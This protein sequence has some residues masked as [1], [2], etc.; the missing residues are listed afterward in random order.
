MGQDSL[1]VMSYNLLNFPN[2]RDDCGSNLSVAARWDTLRKIVQY[3]KPDILMVCELQSEAGADNILNQALNVNNINYYSRA[4]FISNQ[5][6][7]GSSLNNMFFYNS[8]KVTLYNQSEVTTDLRDI[9]EYV[10]Y[11]N[12]PNLGFYNDTTFISFF[13][14]HL[15][16]GNWNAPVEENRRALECNSLRNYVNGLAQGS[17]IVFGG[18]FNFYTSNEAGYQILT[19]GGGNKLNDPINSPGNWNNNSAFANIHTQST[20]SSN[21]IECGAVGGMD[22]RFDI[23]LLS[24]SIIGGGNRVQYIN[25][26]YKAFG[27]DGNGFN[28]AINSPP[29]PSL[30]DSIIEALYYMSDHLPVVLNLSITYPNLLAST[31][32]FNNISCNGSCDGNATIAPIGGTLPHT[33]QWNDPALQTTSTATGLCSGTYMVTLTDNNGLSTV[34]TVS[35]SDPSILV[36]SFSNSIIVTCNGDSSGSASVLSSGGTTPYTYLWNDPSGQTNASAFGLSA[37]TYTVSVTDNNNCLDT[38]VVSI[39]ESSSSPMFA[40]ISTSTNILCS[41]YNTGLAIATTSGGSPPYTYQWNDPGNQTDSI[42]SGLIA[43]T[44]SVQVSDTSGCSILDTVNITE[45]PQLLLTVVDTG[46]ASC[47][48]ANST[49]NILVSGGNGPYTY[50][51]NDP[52]SQTTP[53]AT[54]LASGSYVII[55]TDANGC[56]DSSYATISDNQAPDVTITDSANVLCYGATNG[57]ATVT[58]IGGSAPYTYS[59]SPGISTDSTAQFLPA[60]TYFATVIDAAGCKTVKSVTITQPPQFITSIIDSSDVICSGDS[61]GTATVLALGGVSPYNYLWSNGDTNSIAQNLAPGIYTVLVSD[62]NGCIANDTLTPSSCFEI[63]SI[64]VDA[65]KQPGEPEGY[66]EMVRIHVGYNN[67]NT[68]D[69]FVNWPNNAWKG[70]CQNIITSNTVDSINSTING[71][72]QVVEPVG[73]V[74]P[75]GAQVMLITSIYF[76]WTSHNWSGLDYTLYLIFQCDS[77]KSG[78]FK[79]FC[80]SPCG[81]RTLEISFGLNCGDTVTYEPNLLLLSADGDGA[82]FDVAGNPTYNNSGC[83]PP[84]FTPDAPLSVTI[85]EPPLFTASIA[86]SSNLNCLDDSSG[87]ALVLASGGISP[88]TYLWNDASAQTDSIASGLIAGTYYALVWDNNG[89]KDSLTVTINNPPSPLNALMVDSSDI[90][91]NGSNTGFAEVLASGGTPPLSYLWNDPNTQTAAIANSLIAGNYLVQVTDANGCIDSALVLITEPPPITITL[92]SVTDANCG[93]FNGSAISIASGGVSPYTY[94][95]NDPMSQTDT[96]AN[97]LGPG[98]YTIMVTDSNNC[99][100]SVT[101]VINDLPGPGISIVGSSNLQCNG[102]S[103]GSASSLPGG[104]FPPYT[105][106]WNDPNAQTDSIATGLTAGT[107]TILVTDNYGC[108]ASDSIIITEPSAFSISISN[109]DAG[110]GLLNGT[111]NVNVSGGSPPYSYLWN[112]NPIQTSATATGLGTGSYIVVITDSNSCVD[113]LTSTISNLGGPTIMISDSTNILCNGNATGSATVSVTGGTS[114]FTYL[115]NDLNSQSNAIASGLLAGTYIVTVTDNGNCNS[116][117]SVTLIEPNALGILFSNNPV[118]CNGDSTGS[119]IVSVI[120]G[121][122]P[123]N[124]L[125]NDP[126]SQTDS[127][128]IGLSSGTYTVTI[129]DANNCTLIANDTIKEPNPLISIINTTPESCGNSDGTANITLSGGTPSYSYS[130]NTIPIQTNASATGLI[131]GNYIVVFNDLNGCVDSASASI[132]TISGPQISINNIVNISCNSG[133]DGAVDISISGGTAPYSYLWSNGA[134]TEDIQNLNAG[135]YTVVITDSSNCIDSATFVLSDPSAIVLSFSSTNESCGSNNGSI[136]ANIS[137]GIAPFTYQWD[138]PSA[139]TSSIATGLSA[140]NYSVSVTDSS[141]CFSSS[142]IAITNTEGPNIDTILVGNESCPEMLD[143]TLLAIISGGTL[144]YIYQWAGPVNSTDVNPTTLPSG[145]YSLLI[146]DSLGC[147]AIDSATIFQIDPSCFDSLVIPNSFTPNDDGKNDQWNF[148]GIDNFP[149]II[150]EIYNRWGSM[151]YSSKGYQDPWDGTFEGK[152]VSIATY[153]YIILLDDKQD[154]LKGSV[155]VVR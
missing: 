154:A 97:T 133:G 103:I 110:C 64:L 61:N 99:T 57:F 50:L 14:G 83:T 130:W 120:G 102:D 24:D 131:A 134:I 148:G 119:S 142:S 7:G 45:P 19:T 21:Y 82:D 51:W 96:L 78:H 23:I 68:S 15:K 140:G 56:V 90:L 105:Y 93:L 55:V 44:Y 58:P 12:D 36:A 34:D 8:Q 10:V 17:N 16:A 5:S 89:C 46:S 146:V 71:G 95:W 88:Y 126:N 84:Y 132:S 155:T 27:N 66:N 37:G 85:S 43:G 117:I 101:L 75:A 39:I 87:F 141:G 48:T 122:G 60:G 54:G 25:N 94:Q 149:N 35:L 40:S 69:I 72:G 74:L 113:S 121:I 22:D 42:A 6:P 100:D 73:G 3:I 53:T 98:T 18:D 139:Q 123:Y 65:C 127:S 114:P 13:V 109:V 111:S 106:L 107:Y 49:A 33:Y 143:G 52:T 118:G 79:N 41:G 47:D 151:I 26:S 29:N 80:S 76:D 38:A 77:N 144:P 1:K 128:A 59:W 81:T 104:G 11:A 63:E 86:D 28:Q 138:D 62:A 115:W 153:Y 137:N 145:N 31:M 112:S 30:P 4:N 9:G 129:T 135:S 150:V 108:V 20:R 92:G 70:I 147:T 32:S 136:T 124:Y 116:L 2:G 67:L 125:W 152:P 91:C